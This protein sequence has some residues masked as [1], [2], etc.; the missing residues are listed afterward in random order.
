[1]EAWRIGTNESFSQMESG[2]ANSTRWEVL[3]EDMR[4][5]ETVNK[6]V[7]GWCSWK[8]SRK[9]NHR[10]RIENFWKYENRLIS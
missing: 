2:N 9:G 10:K 3:C 5:F 4:I 6:E 1:M 8:W 7:A